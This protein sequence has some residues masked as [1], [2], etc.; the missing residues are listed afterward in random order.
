VR[1]CPKKRGWTKAQP[2][3][4]NPISTMTQTKT[5]GTTACVPVYDTCTQCP[6]SPKERIYAPPICSVCRKLQPGQLTA[7]LRSPADVYHSEAYLLRCLVKLY[8]WRVLEPGSLRRGMGANQPPLAPAGAGAAK[9]MSS[10][11][12]A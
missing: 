10:E 11:V 12:A 3:S 7:D 5:P 8:G 1:K 6:N 9:A 4:E 2:L